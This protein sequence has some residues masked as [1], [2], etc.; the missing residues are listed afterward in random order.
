MTRWTHR[1]W[2]R[3]VPLATIAGV[4]LGLSIALVAAVVAVLP[5]AQAPRPLAPFVLALLPAVVGVWIDWARLWRPSRR[6]RFWSAALLGL[7]AFATVDTALWAGG[8]ASVGLLA[9]ALPL[10]AALLVQAGARALIWLTGRGRSLVGFHLAC[11]AV[12]GEDAERV[13]LDTPDGVVAID[14]R[15]PDLGPDRPFVLDVGAPLAVLARR[16]ETASPGDPYRTERRFEARTILG[17]AGG[18]SA[19]AA[20][21]RRRAGAWTRYLLGLA[22]AAALLGPALAHSPVEST[23]PER[24]CVLPLA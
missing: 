3:Q 10:G 2:T 21:V 24:G 15:T 14:R 16:T 7:T 22:V 5:V 23:T 1:R 6:T 4:G 18:P 8:E 9:A 11:G 20:R 12:R 13:L 17:V 19:L